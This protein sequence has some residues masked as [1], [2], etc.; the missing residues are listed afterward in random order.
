MREPYRSSRASVV[1]MGA[2]VHSRIW[3]PRAVSLLCG[4][5]SVV[6]SAIAA[7]PAVPA[8]HEQMHQRTGGKNQP[9]QV[10][11]DVRAMLGDQ[12]ERRDAREHEESDFHP[13]IPNTGAAVRL[14][15]H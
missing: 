4:G 6:A 14:L 9:W 10:R 7:V 8:V 11:K 13:R 3:S 15:I 2:R 5:L 1:P 12:Q